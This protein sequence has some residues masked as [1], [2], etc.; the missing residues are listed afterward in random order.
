MT[1]VFGR[2]DQDD[3]V[4]SWGTSAGQLLSR[5][6]KFTQ[7]RVALLAPLLLSI[8]L[9]VDFSLQNVAGCVSRILV[10]SAKI[11]RRILQR[12]QFGIQNKS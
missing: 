3:A 12:C 2:L 1:V 8:I 6:Y 11:M 10:G 5:D 4:R 7:W 9:A